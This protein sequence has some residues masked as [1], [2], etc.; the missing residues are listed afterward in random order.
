M[1][2]V[3]VVLIGEGWKSVVS[4]PVLEVGNIEEEEE[5]KIVLPRTPVPLAPLNV[6]LP[7]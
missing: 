1:I 3:V 4:T 5:A 2:V 7:G 6:L